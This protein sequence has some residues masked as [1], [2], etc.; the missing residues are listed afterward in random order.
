YHQEYAH[1]NPRDDHR[2]EPGH[3]TIAGHVPDEI[4]L[5]IGLGNH[6][7]TIRRYHR[8]SASKSFADNSTRIRVDY[9]EKRLI[10]WLLFPRE[11]AGTPVA[12]PRD[13]DPTAVAMFPRCQ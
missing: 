7:I 5:V 9:H 10:W 4:A 12:S 2:E 1:R 8:N 11:K 3:G 6:Q 13:R